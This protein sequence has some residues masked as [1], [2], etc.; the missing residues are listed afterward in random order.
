[1]ALER[2]GETV[3]ISHLN[4]I[5]VENFLHNFNL[6]MAGTSWTWSTMLAGPGW[7]GCRV[8]GRA[9]CWVLDAGPGAGPGARCQVLPWTVAV[10]KLQV[11]F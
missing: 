10:V 5:P 1:M 2:L 11:K 4:V 9:G 7:A 6:T 3:A 8:P